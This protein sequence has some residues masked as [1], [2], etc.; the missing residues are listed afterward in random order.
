MQSPPRVSVC[1]PA[2]NAEATIHEAVDSALDQTFEDLELV[3]VDDAS[4][5]RTAALLDSIHDPRV[6]LERSA[7]N[8]GQARALNRALALARGALIK[9]LHSDDVLAPDCVQRMV[10][11]MDRE[12]GVGLVFARRRLRIEPPKDPVERK[13]ADEWVQLFGELHVHFGELQPVS[14]GRALLDRY[15]PAALARSPANWLAEPSGVMVRRACLEEVGGLN[16]RLRQAVDVDLWLRVLARWDVGFIDEPLFEYRVGTQGVSG[17]AKADARDWL[18]PLWMLEG[19]MLL[20]D[21]VER[22]PELRE[23]WSQYRRRAV[24][25][26]ASAL[27]RRRPHARRMLSDVASYASF[28][29]RRRM[30]RPAA[31][32]GEV[33]PAPDAS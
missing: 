11:I 12:P 25:K 3:V 2:Y 16:L 9:F 8:G 27:F 26:V 13:W 24:R 5:D 28:R 33:P 32:C 30:G 14:D 22:H 18:D 10:E 15:L 23:Q 31:L 7:V 21:V 20:P 29:A 17:W 19:L 1:L 6:R 4:T